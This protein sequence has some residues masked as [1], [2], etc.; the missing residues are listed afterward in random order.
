MKPKL[1]SR[2]VIRCSSFLLLAAMAI[3]AG[4]LTR[5][6]REQKL[7]APMPANVVAMVGDQAIT[8][9]SLENELTRR[10][11]VSRKSFG[12][13]KEKQAVLEEMIRFEVLHQ[14]AL[15][16]GYDKDPQIVA[17]LKRMVVARFQED[18]LVKLGQP[19]V[20]PEDITHYYND[21]PQRFGTPEKVHAAMIEIKVARTAMAEKRAEVA[22]RAEAVLAEARTNTSSDRT[23]GLVAQKNSEHQP[24]RYRGGDIGWL[25]VGVTNNEWPPAVTEAIFNISRPGEISPVIETPAAFYVVK[26]IERLPA[27]VRPLAEVKDGVVYLVARQKEQQQQ[28]KLLTALKQGLDI[29]IN[30]ALLESISVP[31]RETK[32]PGLPGGQ[33]A[34][35]RN[36][37][38]K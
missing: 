19:E 15:A 9:E 6:C 8:R 29:R 22:A 24:S 3:G 33:T 18:Q 36:N 10:A 7:S 16:A 20:T 14:K 5:S 2:L 30:R 12:D 34:Q 26:L 32:P 28:D 23:F 38:G 37:T 27:S 21:N 25:T 4:C 13:P 11:G 1:H 17:S 35:A 31:A